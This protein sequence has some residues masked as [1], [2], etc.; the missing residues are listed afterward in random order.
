MIVINR[1]K[2]V[3]VINIELLEKLF[4]YA[5]QK[6]YLREMLIIKA[7]ICSYVL[8]ERLPD[9]EK[10]MMQEL[11]IVNFSDSDPFSIKNSIHDTLTWYA[12]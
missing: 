2:I 11:I 10:K 8:D 3:R 7:V 1:Q 9:D 6:L 12:S 5:K 4:L